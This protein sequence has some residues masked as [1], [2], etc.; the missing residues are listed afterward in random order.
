VLSRLL[1]TNTLP[2]NNAEWKRTFFEISF[3]IEGTTEKVNKPVLHE[4][5][6]RSFNKMLLLFKIEKSWT[7]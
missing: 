4:T 2:Y 6:N 5:S 1:V 3:N 7:P